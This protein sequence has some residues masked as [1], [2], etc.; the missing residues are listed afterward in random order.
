[1]ARKLLIGI[2]AFALLVSFS[3]V[4]FAQDKAAQEVTITGTLEKVGE[5]MMVDAYKLA[6]AVDEALVGKKVE[7]KGTVVE[8][9]GVKTLTVVEIKAVE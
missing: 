1:M 4:T 5:D 3:C 6:G 2:L 8:A 7:V 9:E